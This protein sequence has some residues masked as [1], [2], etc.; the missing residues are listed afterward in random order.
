MKVEVS[1]DPACK[2]P[3]VII[4][5]D[6]M[7]DEIENIMQCITSTE[8]NTLS[9][10]SH[11]GVEFINCGDIVRIY[12][13]QK[14]VF[15]QTMVSIYNVRFRLYELEEKLNTQMFV[16]ISNAE[17]VNR[18]M[19]IHMDISKTGTIGVELKGGIKTYASRRYVTKI[20]KQLG[21]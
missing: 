5:T 19:I 13:E 1:I 8:M 14:K 12:T 4:H 9:V 21:F 15:V 7:T 18:N 11:R 6:K 20:K 16:R 10:L 17:I 2:E 3:K